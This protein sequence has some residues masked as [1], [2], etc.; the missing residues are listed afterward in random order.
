[1]KTKKVAIVGLG[2]VGQAV[3]KLFPDAL[4]Y[5]PYRFPDEDPI[6]KQRTISKE[7]DLVIICVPTDQGEDGR[8]IT[9]NVEC[10][11]N[12]LNAF[13]Y[14][15]DILIKSTVPPGTTDALNSRC[16]FEACFSP[17]YIGE[18][19]YY[20]A[21]WKYPDPTEM[22]H[23]TFM[24][25]GGPL[26][27]RQRILAIFQKILGPDKVYYQTDAKTAELIKYGE[28]CWAGMKVVF[29]NELYEICKAFG[30]DYNTFR[31]G[32][33]LDPRVE[34]MH[35]AVFP[36]N[37]GFGGKCLPKDI[38]AIIKASEDVGYE[39]E[40]IKQVLASNEKFRK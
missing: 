28:N 26:G 19:K 30:V 25:I 34:R 37:R 1:L 22:K 27:A 24:I 11:F 32:F 33:L 23:H 39:P 13:D 38:N 15:G 17:E 8:A 4:I 3:N 9:S 6:L 31:E 18:G 12:W 40:L 20:V 36:D 2:Y 14:A 5:D 10:T 35:T 21:P 16:G 7:A 29:C